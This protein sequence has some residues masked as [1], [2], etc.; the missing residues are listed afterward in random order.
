MTGALSPSGS[1]R[2]DYATRLKIAERYRAGE[3]LADL[4]RAYGLHATTINRVLRDLGVPLRPAGGG[5]VGR[6]RKDKPS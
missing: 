1:R 6:K 5:K 2:T 4:G 3:S